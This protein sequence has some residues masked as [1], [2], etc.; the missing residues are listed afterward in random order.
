MTPAPASTSVTLAVPSATPGD[1]RDIRGPVAIPIP[2]LVPALIAG[3]VLLALLLGW[4]ARRWWKRRKLRVPPPRPA[5]EVALERLEAARKLID[6]ARAREFCFAVTEAVRFYI[7]DRFA[8]RAA[9]R[10]T[11]EFLNDLVRTP[12]AGLASHADMLGDVLKQGDLVKFAR[13]TLASDEMEALH[14]SAVRFVQETRP[15]TKADA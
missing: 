12:T 2:W 14:R 13:A 3:G 9:R 6:P 1:I 4:L 15:G 10:T 7:E 8:V 11:D 5:D